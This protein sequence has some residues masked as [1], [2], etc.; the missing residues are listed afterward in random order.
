MKSYFYVVFIGHQT[1]IFTCYHSEVLPAIT[2][3]SGAKYY[4]FDDYASALNVW[5]IGLEA[6]E[7]K[8]FRDTSNDDLEFRIQW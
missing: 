3:F 2:G 4:G 5:K 8:R 1:G 6:Y 7:K